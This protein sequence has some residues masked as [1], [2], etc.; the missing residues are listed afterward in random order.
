MNPDVSGAPVLILGVT[1][2]GLSFVRSLG[3]RGIRVWMLDDARRPGMRSRFGPAVPMPD[4]SD[5]PARWLS[6]I[7]SLA[8]QV[9][10]P[11]VLV[12]TGDEHVLFVS[13]H[14]QEL[15][16]LV[17]FRIPV[18]EVVE[19]LCDKRRQYEW[20]GRQGVPM[21]G[22]AFLDEGADPVAIAERSV[23]FPCVLKPCR[24]HRWKQKHTGA[25]LVLAPDAR[26]L[27]EAHRRIAGTGEPALLQEFI[28]GDDA[29]LHGYLA[30]CGEGG[31]PVAAMT[32]RKLRQWPLAAG[33]GSLQISTRNE[34]VSAIS[35]RLLRAMNYRGL[36]AIEYK[37][38]AR[39]RQYKII[40]INPRSVSGNQ[41][42]VNAGIDLPWVA[43]RDA[44]NLTTP[45]T[46]YRT[47]LV[48]LHLGW[49]VQAFLGARRAG[50]LTAGAWIRSL[51][52][53]RS[54][55]LFSWRDPMPFV[56]YAHNGIRQCLREGRPG[57]TT[58]LRP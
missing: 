6:V 57:G 30:Y 41:L 1:T 53:V 21:P 45:P 37:W 51:T 18:S 9:G 3:A 20:L 22:T 43:Y 55:A 7:A 25:K 42:A 15:E 33:N 36:V 12:A 40:E 24:S 2:N 52:A 47:G 5:D 56:A 27:L 35:E 26:T 34:E 32:K 11:P 23:G 50:L 54:T 31:R 4:V 28:P 8:R 39:D 13:S 58:A 19:T 48:Y 38:D 10:E 29:T 46:T 16:S 49:D 14:R 44:L 17:R